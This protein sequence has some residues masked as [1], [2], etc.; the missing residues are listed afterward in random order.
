MRMGQ[1]LQR[2]VPPSLLPALAPPLPRPP[3]GQDPDE[4]TCQPVVVSEPQFSDLNRLPPELA[5]TVLANL[6]ATDLCLASCVW[7]QLASDNILW[8]GLCRAQWSYASIYDSP[9]QVRYRQVY[10]WLDEG[11]LTFN[12]DASE[13]MNY[14][15]QRGLVTDSALEIARFIHGTSSLRRSRVRQFTQSRQDVVSHLVSLQN[16]ANT[17]LPNALRSFFSKLEAPN[18]RGTYLQA[19]CA[20]IR[21]VDI[22]IK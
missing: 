3:S 15:I 21:S 7:Q 16:F 22:V 1:T 10:L 4:V 5:L 20:V 12:A 9:G 6:N 13:G 2:A 14:F 17:F 18:E 11:T 19:S 8:Q